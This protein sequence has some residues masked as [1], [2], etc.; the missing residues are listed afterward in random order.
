MAKALLRVRGHALDEALSLSARQVTGIS[1]LNSGL[2]SLLL[3][4][5]A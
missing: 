4:P 3:L 2:M 1:W 5:I